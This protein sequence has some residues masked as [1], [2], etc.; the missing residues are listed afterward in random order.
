MEKFEKLQAYLEEQSPL[1]L[2]GWEGFKESDSLEENILLILEAVY[3]R[4]FFT[5]EYGAEVIATRRHSGYRTF[6]ELHRLLTFY[7]KKSIPVKELYIALYNLISRKE[8]VSWICGQIEK[9]IYSVSNY[10]GRGLGFASEDIDEFEVSFKEDLG[11]D[12]E[13]CRNPITYGVDYDKKNL[14]S[15]ADY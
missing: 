4:E 5:F 2:R 1:Y 3:T 14:T 13:Q 11:L 12:V 6:K 9:R 7:L 8:I 15:Y 10:R